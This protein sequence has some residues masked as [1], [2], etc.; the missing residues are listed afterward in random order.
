LWRT[1][2]DAA[3][4]AQAVVKTLP[5]IVPFASGPCNGVVRTFD[6][7]VEEVLK[8][9][10]TRSDD[11]SVTVRAER[12]IIV[13][14][15]RL[16][17]GGG[18][19]AYEAGSPAG[20]VT[21]SGGC[22]IVLA[23]ARV[24]LRPRLAASA[25]LV[26]ILAVLAGA[27]SAA[28]HDRHHGPPPHPPEAPNL[29]RGGSFEH[30]AVQRGRSHPFSSIRGWRLAYGPDFELQNALLGPAAAGQQYAELDSDASIGIFQRVP[31][32]A[33][34][35]YR[36]EFCVSARP[37]TPPAENVL[38]VRWHRHLLTRIVLDGRKHRQTDWHAYAFTVRASGS[39]TRLQFNERGI[40][41]SVG[42]LLDAVR[43]TRG[44]GGGAGHDGEKGDHAP[45]PPG[46]APAPHHPGK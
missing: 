24:S 4:P 18:S 29:V 11:K 23:V 8:Q 35:S 45:P 16:K 42:T 38:L 20:G 25:V 2:L 26:L 37:G 9:P 3:G 15:G 39:R 40:S 32:R 14:I 6:D 5:S 46:C 34:M 30:P 12:R 33:H 22:A 10:L 41:D 28:A 13:L 17:L 43:L 36:L 21:T 7:G 1:Q 27:S 31:T 44:P 19:A